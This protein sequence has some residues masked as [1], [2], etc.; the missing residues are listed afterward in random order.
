MS[1]SLTHVI[2]KKNGDE[3]N[4]LN[5]KSI[6]LSEHQTVFHTHAVTSKRQWH[7]HFHVCWE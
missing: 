7:L 2:N 4:D 5:N 3:M 1:R 6:C